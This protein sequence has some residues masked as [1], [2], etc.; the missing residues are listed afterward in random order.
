MQPTLG[1][2]QETMV[3]LTKKNLDVP[4][5]QRVTKQHDKG[6]GHK[7]YRSNYKIYHM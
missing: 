3:D 1:L 4:N 5:M 2:K 6:W 7:V